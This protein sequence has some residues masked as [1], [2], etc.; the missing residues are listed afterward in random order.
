MKCYIYKNLVL[1]STRIMR[2]LCYL[3]LLLGFLACSEQDWS[4]QKSPKSSQCDPEK[5]FGKE[6]KD[7]QETFGRQ[8]FAEGCLAIH[9]D[10]DTGHQRGLPVIITSEG[11]VFGRDPKTGFFDA[12]PNWSKPPNIGNAKRRIR[13]YV[14]FAGAL[15][16]QKDQAKADKAQQALCTKMAQQSY[17]CFADSEE[18][19]C[20]FY[21]TLEPDP[22]PKDPKG[23]PALTCSLKKK[24]PPVQTSDCEQDSDCIKLGKNFVCK[25]KK[26]VEEIPTVDCSKDPHLG[27]ACQAPSKYGICKP[28]IYKCEND[29][30][31]CVSSQAPGTESCNNKDDDCDGEVDEGLTGDKCQVPNLQAP[32]AQGTKTCNQGNFV[33]KSDNPPIPE[34]CNQKDDNCNGKIDDGCR[35]GLTFGQSNHEVAYGLAVTPQGAVYACGLYSNDLTFG[36]VQLKARGTSGTDAFVIKISP[37]GKVL[38]ALGFGGSGTDNC[39]G[40]GLAPDGSLYATGGFAGSAKFGDNTLVSSGTMLAY[41]AKISPEGK[42]LWASSIGDFITMG[43]SVAVDKQNNPYVAGEFSGKLSTGS[44]S[45][46]STGARDAFVGKYSAK[47][48]K[49]IWA[50]GFGAKGPDKAIDLRLGPKGAVYATGVLSGSTKIDGKEIAYFGGLTDIFLIKLSPLGKVEW[51]K[52][53]GGTLV[54]E[55]YAVYAKDDYVL[56][57]GQFS[58]TGNFG[59]IKKLSKGGYEAFVAKIKSDGTEVWVKSFGGKHQD[60]G[61]GLHIDKNDDIYVTGSFSREV[62]IGKQT[63]VAHGLVDGFLL[64]MDK[65]GNPKNAFAFGGKGTEYGTLVH[66]DAGGNIYITGAFDALLEIGPYK[67]KPTGSFTRDAFV[68]KNAQLPVK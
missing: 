2:G 58:R 52:G 55:G 28:G 14:L 33:C 5:V 40:L 20:W 59:T 17:D 66:V 42:V 10:T 63:I 12:S 27:Q 13:L 56:L 21:Y 29:K 62:T 37:E 61:Y 3:V 44:S 34:N 65:E 39:Y 25:E 8:N 6:N 50:R 1:F 49:V 16:P 22:Q 48:G 26:C 43:Q 4:K 47:S 64:H 11:K 19:I 15:P 32:C 24:K 31:T 46:Q 67:Y 23:A 9:W 45:I 41:L 38:W 57:S 53:Y 68:V 36:S 30:L 7:W 51:A 18:K 54:D 60:L 35:W